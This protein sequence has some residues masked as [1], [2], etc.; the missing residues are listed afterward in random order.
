MDE[1]RIERDT[2]GEVQVPVEALWGAQTQ[3][4]VQNF[5]VSG[6]ALPYELIVALAQIKQA[7]AA[8]NAQTGALDSSRRR[9]D[10]RGRR[11]RSSGRSR[12]AFPDRRL[13]DR[14]GHLDQHERERG[15]GPARRRR[16]GRTVHPNDQVNASQSS[17]DVFPSAIHLAAVE[18]LTQRL[19]PGAGML[20]STLEAR[21]AEFAEV[22]KSGRTH[23]MDATPVTLGQ[24]FSGYASR[25]GAASTGCVGCCPRLAELPLG[26]TAVGTGVNASDDFRRLVFAHLRGDRP[27]GHRGGEPLRGA[28]APATRWSSCPASCARSPVS[29]YKIAN[30][31][32]WMGFGPAR[33]P[34]RAAHPRSAAGFVDHAGQGEPGHLRVGAPGLRPG[35]R[36]RRDGRLRRHARAISSSTS[37]CRSSPAT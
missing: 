23:L 16:L 3:R 27:A 5:P 12:R 36:Q 32:R 29:L 35:H 9:R 8:A 11:A 25:C 10:R 15:A 33:G 6:A 4:A 31:I 30:D 20:A 14:L 2:M 37:C 13:P 7:A 28:R 24:E 34:P 18:L 19:Q 1:Y 17:N 21:S 26:G 22:V